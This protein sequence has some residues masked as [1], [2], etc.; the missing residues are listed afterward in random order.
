MKIKLATV[1]VIIGMLFSAWLYIDK[2][3]ADAVDLEKNSVELEVF[4]Q[5]AERKWDE[6][7]WSRIRKRLWS[8]EEHYGIVEAKVLKEYKELL[9]EKEKLELKLKIIIENNGN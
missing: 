1:L 8:L 5:R 2:T 4:K 6:D 3:K 9:L 7:D